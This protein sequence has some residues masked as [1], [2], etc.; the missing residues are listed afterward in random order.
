MWPTILNNL[1]RKYVESNE[2][3]IAKE[4][5]QFNCNGIEQDII[6]FT[7]LNYSET[8]SENRLM[9]NR[10]NCDDILDFF[11]LLQAKHNINLQTVSFSDN[12]RCDILMQKSPDKEK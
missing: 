9:E 6:G 12:L 11:N 5:K 2:Q 4:L 7:Y 3:K 1:T 10:A 8:N